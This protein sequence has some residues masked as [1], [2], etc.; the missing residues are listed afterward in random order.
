VP[1]DG[2]AGKM[3]EPTTDTVQP[4]ALAHNS[5]W[6]S[7]T[8]VPHRQVFAVP[9][10]AKRVVSQKAAWMSVQ[11][12]VQQPAARLQGFFSTGLLLVAS[13][14]PRSFAALPLSAVKRNVPCCP[15]Y[16]AKGKKGRSLG[17][18]TCRGPDHARRGGY[19][20][21]SR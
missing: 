14:T 17:G 9:L 7:A 19:F 11:I 3:R 12:R 13:Q 20:V 15:L 6:S 8:A 1:E 2:N 5:R 4:G 16:G 10:V 18:K 21:Q